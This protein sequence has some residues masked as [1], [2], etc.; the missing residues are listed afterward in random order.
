MAT[1][2]NALRKIP[3]QPPWNTIEAAAPLDAVAEGT[4]E[5]DEG[6]FEV[7][8]EKPEVVAK[9]EETKVELLL[10]VAR[11]AV[12]C[13]LIWLRISVLKVPVMP[14]KVNLEENAIAGY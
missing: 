11:G 3:V 12:D 8:V 4:E 10:G 5:V 2:K 6:F 1:P 13:P 14:D 7:V 9:G